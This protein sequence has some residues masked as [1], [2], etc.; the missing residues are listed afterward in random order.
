MAKPTI[1]VV[2][3]AAR[4]VDY[5]IKVN[6]HVAYYHAQ[7]LGGQL[8]KTG[9]TINYYSTSSIT[10]NLPNADDPMASTNGDFIKELYL[11]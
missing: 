11:N 10:P 7:M 4:K 9:P 1:G 2:V 5:S 8:K 6:V 3:V